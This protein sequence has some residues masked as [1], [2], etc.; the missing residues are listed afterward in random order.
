MKN[1]LFSLRPF[2]RVAIPV[3]LVLTLIGCGFVA[4][5]PWIRS[6]EKNHVVNIGD[7]IFA[8]S[9]EIQEFLHAYSGT[10]FR[11]YA[12]S[13]AELTGGIMAPSVASQYNIAKLDDPNIDTI[14]MDGGGNDILL[15]VLTSFDPYNCRTQW[16][17]FGRLSSRCK[18]FIDDIYVECVDLLNQMAADKVGE[19][20]YL[21]YYYTKNTWLLQLAN[22][23][24]AIDYGNLRLSQACDYSAVGCTFVDPRPVITNSDILVDAIHP[25]RSGS[26]KIANLIWPVLGPRL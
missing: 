26:E 6:A 2:V 11:R 15:P 23:K 14:L 17:Q 5:V 10:T 21:G 16:Y 8:L 20:V 1:Q 9:G 13:G 19:V 25:T 24:Q 3:I 12:V 7:S 4:S 22:L 18:N